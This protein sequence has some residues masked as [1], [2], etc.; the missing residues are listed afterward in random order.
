[1]PQTRPIKDTSRWPDRMAWL[2]DHS[3]D[4]RLR[5]F[6]R[7]G[8]RPPETPISQVPMVALDFETTGLDP[9]QH[10]IVSMGLVPFSY[11]RIRLPQARHWVLK[12]RLP[13]EEESVTIHGITHSDIASAPDLNLV[14]DDLLQQLAGRLVVVHYR[15]IERPF[16]DG[17]L[18]SRI[19][20]GIEFPVIDTMDLE[21][22][23]H[24][25]KPPGFMDRLLGRKPVSIR[26]SAARERL[27]LPAYKAHNA[28]IDAIATAELLQAQLQHRFSANTPVGKLWR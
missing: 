21:A 16:L 15:A 19:G 4:P 18:L 1:M 2:A 28:L 12:P 11:H 6:Y 3:Q 25:Q 17:A 13:L 7:A 26:L 27:G 5:D 8:C 20:E 24:R 23:L 9:S 10:G 14:I 22:R